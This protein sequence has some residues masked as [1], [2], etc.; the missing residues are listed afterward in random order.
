MTR[1]KDRNSRHEKYQDSPA[2]FAR[3]VFLS[4]ARTAVALFLTREM[5][6]FFAEASS[7]TGEFGGGS[8]GR[9]VLTLPSGSGGREFDL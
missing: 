5:D 7:G 4:D 3:V 2:L 6:L 8:E 1:K 9:R